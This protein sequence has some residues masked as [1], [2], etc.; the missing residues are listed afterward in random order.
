M[1]RVCALPGC[2]V[3]FEVTTNF[4]RNRMLPEF[5]STKCKRAA[6]RLRSAV[7]A[8][9]KKQKRLQRKQFFL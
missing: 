1:K 8:K 2:N 4:N 6:Q 3:E 5:C 7:Y 9:K